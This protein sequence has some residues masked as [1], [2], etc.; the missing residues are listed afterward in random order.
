[1]AL[2]EFKNVVKNFGEIEALKDVSFEIDEGEMVF[3][4]GPS[5]AGK[6]TLLR[7]LIRQLR[8]LSGEIIFDGDDV[9]KIKR[10]RI[11]DLRRKV[12]AVFQ[13][14]KLLS[15]RTV[16]ENCN[17]ALA[18]AKIPHDEWNSRVDHILELVGLSDRSELFPQQLSG[19]ELQRAALARSLVMNP[20][21]IFADE[22]TGNLDWD[23]A[24]EIMN[25]LQ[26]IHQEG[27]TI[28]VTTHHKKIIKE[29]GTRLI[30]LNRGV[31]VGDNK[32]GK[33]EKKEREGRKE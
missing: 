21:I 25:L 4:T 16:R 31:L 1:M 9:A 20:K 32:H 22:P 7:L 18:I 27:K 23:T 8:P 11:P 29:Y 13:D 33:I 19:G 28:I 24:E 30:E 10:R 17:I 6:T 26:K 14:F 5:G 12:G 3:I 15:E 2:L